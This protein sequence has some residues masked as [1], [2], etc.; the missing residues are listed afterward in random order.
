MELPF[1]SLSIFV[2]RESFN[3]K[4]KKEKDQSKEYNEW[5][6]KMTNER[7]EEKKMNERKGQMDE[8]DEKSIRRREK[9]C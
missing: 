9:F 2:E 4:L 7:N 3:F 8:T 5:K 6:G 1:A